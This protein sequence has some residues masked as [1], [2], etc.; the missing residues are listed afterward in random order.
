[1]PQKK[2]LRDYNPE[3]KTQFHEELNAGVSFDE[4]FI[5]F[6]QKVFWNC[7]TGHLIHQKPRG[8]V[9]GKCL[10]C[11]TERGRR[12]LGDY[13]QDLLNEFDR[14]L[15]EG[16]DPET[17]YSSIT[18][19]Y[20]WRCEKGN[21]PHTYLATVR[22]RVMG[23][24]CQ[25]CG[26]GQVLPGLNDWM[27]LEPLDDLSW[28]YEKNI[29]ES[30]EPLNPQS[31]GVDDRV[32]RY[33]T[34]L[35]GGHERQIS[36][37]SA[38]NGKRL[39]K[40]CRVCS[41]YKTMPGITDAFSLF[42]TLKERLHPTL[43][44]GLDLGDI[45]PGN[46]E[47]KIHW[48]CDQNHIWERSVKEELKANGCGKCSGRDLWEGHNDLLSQYPLVAQ[49]IAYD[50]NSKVAGVVKDPPSRI[51]RFSYLDS[52]WRCK[53]HGHTWRTT[54][55][56]RTREG[57]GC[58]FCSNRRVW[59]GFNDLWTKR[60]DLVDEIDFDKHANLNPKKLLWSSHEV[61]N[62][63]CAEGHCWPT[64][65]HLRSANPS[66][67]GTGC[68]SCAVSGFKP[69]EPAILYFILQKDL[70][71]FKVGITNIN[72]ERLSSWVRS[73]WETLEIF[74]FEVGAEARFVEKKFHFWRKEILRAPDFLRPVD[75]GRNGGWTETFGISTTSADVVRA[76][77][78]E[79][80]DIRSKSLII[81]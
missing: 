3:L 62:W 76:K 36:I 65:L 40:E 18:G 57:T 81:K 66:G 55:E 72:T 59:P 29:D 80:L 73:G 43:N 78:R 53:E 75:V 71:S 23:H 7:P 69:E 35:R 51:H 28:N 46:Y 22:S 16:V 2:L 63:R 52:W 32:Q 67:K 34:C 4:L 5:I 50:L 39:G 41:G 44:S 27:T 24:S 56:K 14:E 61:L 21:R 58:P 42:P 60:P 6:N 74:H 10:P 47:T 38:V 1:M 9:Q 12:Y 30:G 68:P 33:W 11:S 8:R 54:V 70:S 26:S 37:S 15:N 64:K 45:H 25:Y 13:G 79:I 48:L 19:K 17:L 20:H 77:I 31:F 49:E